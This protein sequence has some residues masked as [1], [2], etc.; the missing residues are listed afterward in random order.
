MAT[1]SKELKKR[2]QLEG[3]VTSNKMMKTL[4]VKVDN[5]KTHP[6]YKKSYVVSKKYKAHDAY[7]NFK[8]GDKVT[9]EEARPMSREKRWRVLPKV[10]PKAA[11]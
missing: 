2:R 7:G 6:I 8:I 9:I 11:K 4:V 1:E 10:A 3:V 5:L